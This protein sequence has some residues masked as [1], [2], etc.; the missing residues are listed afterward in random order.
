MTLEKGSHEKDEGAKH[1]LRRTFPRFEHHFDGLFE[2]RWGES[3]SQIIKAMLAGF[4][5]GE[6]GTLGVNHLQF[7][8]V[9][10]VS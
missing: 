1:E 10:Q 7:F 9:F 3:C 4:D 8:I 6:D 5:L 2:N